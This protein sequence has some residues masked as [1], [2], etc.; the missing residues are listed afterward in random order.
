MAEYALIIDGAYKETRTLPQ[1]PVDIPHKGV[2]WLPIEFEDAEYDPRNQ[3]LS[4]AHKIRI[5]PTACVK[6]RE[7]ETLS[8]AEMVNK[9]IDERTRR[10]SL[11]FD[12]D[13]GDSRGI[14][15]I[16]TTHEDLIGWDEVTKAA[17]A[18]V[19]LGAGTQTIN[20][21][22]DTGPVE[23]TATEWLQIILA[24]TAARQPIWAASFALQEM[25]PIPANYADDVRWE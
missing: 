15:R 1:Q 19:S 22:T 9:V 8:H 23:V 16:G 24:A 2:V 12:Y 25:N 7:A 4:P 11:G 18:F 3:R 13:F 10:L 6:Y 5:E 20:V 21:V 17:T 14:H